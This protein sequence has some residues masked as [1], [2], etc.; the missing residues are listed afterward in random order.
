MRKPSSSQE[1]LYKKP[2]TLSIQKGIYLKPIDLSSWGGNHPRPI[3]RWRYSSKACQHKRVWTSLV[4]VPRRVV[5]TIEAYLN[6]YGLVP[7]MLWS[8]ERLQSYWLSGLF[9][10]QKQNVSLGRMDPV[11]IPKRG[12][13]RMK[14]K[15]FI[16][17]Y[18][19]LKA[20][21][22]FSRKPF[23]LSWLRSQIMYTS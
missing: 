21:R 1:T 5:S 12:I 20:N 11:Y 9:D 15:T 4:F 16:C 8:S 3:L 22:D 6:I 7:P 18:E 23:H 2:I 14:M 10:F 13:M 19:L 17:I